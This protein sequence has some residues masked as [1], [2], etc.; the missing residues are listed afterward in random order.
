M[1]SA[2]DRHPG[3]TTQCGMYCPLPLTCTACAAPATLT[4]LLFEI[5]PEAEVAQHLEEGVVAGRD[6]HVLNV[7][8]A[9]TLLRRGGPR[10][11]AGGLRYIGGGG[12]IEAAA[13]A[14]V[15]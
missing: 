9:H 8:G 13:I 2:H 14:A 15:D 4:H 12:G 1:G 3:R 7:I 11:L 6:A 5:V 10:H